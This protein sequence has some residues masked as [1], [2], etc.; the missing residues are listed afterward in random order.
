[1][2]K[3]LE[4]LPNGNIIVGD[5]YGSEAYPQLLEITKDKKVVWTFKDLEHL[6]NYTSAICTLGNLSRVNR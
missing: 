2:T 6:G 3:Q 1:M 4:E 5:T